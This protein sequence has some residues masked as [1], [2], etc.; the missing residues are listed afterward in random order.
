MSNKQLGIDLETLVHNL[1]LSE[2]AIKVLDYPNKQEL[3]TLDNA[4]TNFTE[5]GALM[6]VN[7]NPAATVYSLP[8]FNGALYH[9]DVKLMDLNFNLNTPTQTIAVYAG[10]SYRC[11][12]WSVTVSYADANDEIG[13]YETVVT[14]CKLYFV[15][16][17]RKLHAYRDIED[18]SESGGDSSGTVIDVSNVGIF[19][20]P[21]DYEDQYN[22]VL[23]DMS[24]L[25]DILADAE[26]SESA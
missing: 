25:N 10:M 22:T 7:P 11:F 20:C 15:P 9:G 26:E 3:V 19:G 8:M 5:D 1:D 18:E 23:G 14:N 2:S 12:K 13:T 6:F 17:R 24:E 21:T 16:F 4:L